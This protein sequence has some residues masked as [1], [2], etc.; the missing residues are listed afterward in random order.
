[1]AWEFYGI[2]LRSLRDLNYCL[3]ERYKTLAKLHEAALDQGHTLVTQSIHVRL[4]DLIAIATQYISRAIDQG[5]KLPDVQ[6]GNEIAIA[7]GPGVVLGVQGLVAAE[8]PL[9][10]LPPTSDN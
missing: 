4:M 8:Y 1:V 10:K 6:P 3:G 2:R 9:Y 5:V 7:L